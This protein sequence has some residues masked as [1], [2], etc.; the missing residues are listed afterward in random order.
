MML[1]TI[2]KASPRHSSVGC[3][4]LLSDGQS[5]SSVTFAVTP[6]RNH[7][8]V[9][10]VIVDSHEGMLYGHPCLSFIGNLDSTPAV[11]FEHPRNMVRSI[12]IPFIV[13]NGTIMPLEYPKIG[14]GRTESP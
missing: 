10:N 6:R 7:I 11:L 13:M 4:E 14:I 9:L 5:T 1:K 8:S 2:E 3:A 12:V